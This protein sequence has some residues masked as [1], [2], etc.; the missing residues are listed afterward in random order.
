[1]QFWLILIALL[2][3]AYFS[4]TET[5]FLSVNRIRLEGFLRRRKF[6]A[7]T[8]RHFL[9]KPSRFILTTLVGNNLANITFSSLLTAFLLHH[10]FPAGWT[11]PISVLAVLIFAEIIPKSLGRDLADTGALWS[12]PPLR[13]FQFLLFPVIAVTRWCSALILAFFGIAR[14]DVRQFF[15]RRD[16]EVLIREGLK[17]GGIHT[18]HETLLTRVFQ[19]A[20][21][22]ADEI[23]TPRTEIVALPETADMEDFRRTVLTSGYSKIPVYRR[24]LDH[25]IGVVYALD[26][27]NHPRDLKSIIKPIAF[28]PDQKRALELFRDMRL[29]HQTIAVVVDEW[30]GTAGLVTHE[31]IIEEVTGDIED[32]YDRTRKRLR[33]LDVNR[34][35]VS[36]RMEV[37]ELNERLGLNLPRGDYVTLGGFLIS[38]MGRIPTAGEVWEDDGVRFRI[39]RASQT[40]IFNVVVSRTYEP[41]D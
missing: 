18:P 6:G 16:L 23:M 39:A 19:L 4:C 40:R 1:M 34:W 32:E 38:K 31:D 15:T 10:G 9:E 13:F 33:R 8:A 30:G 7:K 14:D 22:K 27:F 3:S 17:T 2:L 20:A 11:L 5:V 35:L 26:L 36:G 21:L 25:I 12:A 41:E 29:T 37:E 24:D 28:F